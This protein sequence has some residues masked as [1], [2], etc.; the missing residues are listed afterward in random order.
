MKRLLVTTAATATAAFSV[1][2]PSVAASADDQGNSSISAVSTSWSGS[3]ATAN[4]TY[5]TYEYGRVD[6]IADGTTV[7]TKVLPTWADGTTSVSF[8]RAS[9]AGAASLSV[10]VTSCDVDP[11]D[12]GAICTTRTVYTGTLL[13]SKSVPKGKAN[14]LSLLNALKV[15]KET[16]AGS[17]ARSKF[18]LW[19]DANRDGENTRAEVLKAESTKR[20][21]ENS[22]HTVLSGRWVS[23]YDGTVVKT[24]SKL[25]IDHLVPLE[26]AWTSGA[27]AWSAKKR[28]A[29]ANDLG[30]AASLI[31]VSQH[32]NRSKGDKDPSGYLPP[33]KAYQCAYVRNYIA[34][35]SRWHLSIDSAEKNA[36]M[37]VLAHCSY[38][39]T[40]PGTPV[41]SNLIP[42]P[43]PKP[44]SHSG[45]G[46]SSGGSVYYAN[47]D[48][49]RAAGKAPLYAGQPGYETPRLDRD[50]D[51]VACE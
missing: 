41:I 8:A 7:A 18:E 10:K 44:V 26:E 32:A 40:K 13:I 36:I 34:V 15:T 37:T 39:V 20:V 49:V 16:H 19:A 24:A 1:L 9:S 38:G 33:R 28:E 14:A 3:T 2:V 17:Y 5:D 22:H 46:S 29:Y 51:G 43:K 35:K 50:G 42:K 48:A 31:A 30:Y 11:V 6:V 47:C 45:G 12:S 4:F 21:T 27:Y 25:D 23:R